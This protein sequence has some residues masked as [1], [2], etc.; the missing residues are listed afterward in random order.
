MERVEEINRKD[1]K[2]WETE[3]MTF[4]VTGNAKSGKSS[5]INAIRGI[6]HGD[7]GYAEAS[8]GV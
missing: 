2:R 3:T 7:V 6:K 8:A 4:A 1:L 5:F